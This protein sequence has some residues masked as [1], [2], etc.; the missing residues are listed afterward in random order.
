MNFNFCENLH[1]STNFEASGSTGL[2]RSHHNVR[3]Q[4]LLMQ[5]TNKDAS[6]CTRSVASDARNQSPEQV[7]MKEN[8]EKLTRHAFHVINVTLFGSRGTSSANSLSSSSSRVSIPR[9]ARFREDSNLGSCIN[10]QRKPLR[11]N[12]SQGARAASE[13]FVTTS[14]NCAAEWHQRI[15]VPHSTR[16]CLSA[17]ASTSDSCLSDQDKKTKSEPRHR[18]HH[19]SSPPEQQEFVSLQI[20]SFENPAVRTELLSSTNVCRQLRHRCLPLLESLLQ[21]KILPSVS[22][23]SNA[24]I[25]ETCL[26]LCLAA[27]RSLQ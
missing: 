27:T 22:I 6:R 19:D 15:I 18:G 2:I 1:E 21:M 3:N 10:F 14:P 26:T 12:S 9:F 13:S 24:K 4:W 16:L 17:S 7:C 8:C 11:T 20:A 25:S 5:R 23:D